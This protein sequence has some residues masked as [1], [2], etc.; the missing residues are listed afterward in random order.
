M[1]GRVQLEAGDAGQ[2]VRDGD[3]ADLT[4]KYSTVLPAGTLDVSV[5]GI[6][7]SE[8]ANSTVLEYRSLRPVPEPTDA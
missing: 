1:V 3:R 4:G 5:A 2:V 8:P 7:E 6:G